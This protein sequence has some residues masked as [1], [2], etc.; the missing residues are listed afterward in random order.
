MEDR[1]PNSQGPSDADLRALGLEPTRAWVRQRESGKAL[2]NRRH[3]EKA[4]AHGRRQLSITVPDEA[5]D[6]VRQVCQALCR[7]HL[8]VVDLHRVLRRNA[9]SQTAEERPAPQRT[10]RT[11][12]LVYQ[13]WITARDLAAF[14]VGLGVGG[15]LS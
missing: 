12:R 9:F 5:R 8:T 3:R 4:A 2:R 10:P 6:T 13:T 14:I 15:L 1:N 7:E 11:L